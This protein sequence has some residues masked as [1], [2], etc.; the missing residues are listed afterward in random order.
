VGVKW[1]V[2]REPVV[3]KGLSTPRTIP[4]VTPLLLA[5]EVVGT[6]AVHGETKEVNSQF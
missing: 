2:G 6:P 5:A 3:G 4:Q 1:K